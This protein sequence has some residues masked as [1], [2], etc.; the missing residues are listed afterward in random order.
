VLEGEIEGVKQ[1]SEGTYEIDQEMLDEALSDTNQL[2]TQ[3]R[4]IPQEDG[5][6]FFAIRPNSIF[7]KIGLRNGD[8]IHKI[9]EV[10]LDNIEN[11]LKLF[12]ELRGQTHFSID[13]T[14]RGQNLTY[15]YTVK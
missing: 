4:A 1:V 3:A 2:L 5:L 7:F 15:E 13:L 14:R 12:E 9:N 11:A 6:R 8:V 10:E